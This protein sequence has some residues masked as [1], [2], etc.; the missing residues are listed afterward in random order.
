MVPDKAAIA[1]LAVK[2]SAKR[3]RSR[4]RL[5]FEAHVAS[6]WLEVRESTDGV[7]RE[8]SV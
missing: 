8:L 5:P 3:V 2:C 1:S 7:R 4:E 6:H